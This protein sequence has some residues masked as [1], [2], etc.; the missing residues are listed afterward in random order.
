[1]FLLISTPT[2]EIVR[3]ISSFLSLFNGI[4]C[5]PVAIYCC[6]SSGEN[7]DFITFVNISNSIV[8]NLVTLCS[9]VVEITAKETVLLTCGSI[10]HAV[11]VAQFVLEYQRFNRGN[12]HGV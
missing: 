4:S 8:Y 11:K 5:M 3:S 7:E 2:I 1:K 10:F 9:Q 6:A 12:D